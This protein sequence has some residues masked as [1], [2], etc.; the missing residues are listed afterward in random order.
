MAFNKENGSGNELICHRVG[1]E[2]EKEPA[3]LGGLGGLRRETEMWKKK[4]EE[5]GDLKRRRKRVVLTRKS[6]FQ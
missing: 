2:R 4:G 5:K 1:G 6:C 3:L